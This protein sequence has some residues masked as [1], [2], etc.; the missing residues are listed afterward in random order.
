MKIELHD[1]EATIRA[2]EAK[3][4]TLEERLHWLTAAAAEKDSE[5]VKLKYYKL[6]LRY[7]SLQSI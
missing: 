2:D 5:L 6:S 1:Q 3:I 7:I 4:K